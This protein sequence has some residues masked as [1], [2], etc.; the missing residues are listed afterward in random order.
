MKFATLKN[1][2]RD[3]QLLLVSQDTN[4]CTT[5]T[6]LA[7]NLQYALDHWDQLLAA[8]QARYQALNLGQVATAMP[9]PALDQLHSPLPRAYE[10]V[11]G[12]AYINHIL[13]VRKARNA[14]P[15]AT[16]ETDPL[17]YQGGSGTFLAPSEAIP[18]RDQAWGVDF[19]SEV[20]V[21]L[22]DTP[23]GVQ[24]K[25]AQA[26]VKLV[27]IANDV[28]LRNLIPKELE[29]GFGFFTSKP[30]TAF[31]P[32]AV[33]P[34]ELAEAWQGGRLHLKVQ[35]KLNG[36]VVGDVEAGPEMHFSFFD[37]IQHITQ[38]RSYTAG[39]ILGSGTVSNR[40]PQAGISCLAERRTR[41][42]IEQGSIQTPY[43]KDGDHV[44]I[45]VFVNG[46]SFFGPISQTVK[47]V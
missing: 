20:A 17:V 23:M 36:L 39:T 42:Q 37:L 5:L 40:D 11:D 28:T 22:G 32:I 45:N 2:T 7:P 9:L 47:Q 12:S 16:L 33:T 31:A 3:G 24:A 14:Q 15:P 18:M 19:E 26:Y 13:L 43:L 41:E 1:G 29:K 38:T 34:D 21:I 25:E 44:E 6:D 10:W 30:S 46:K 27:M 4:T 35:T 8:L